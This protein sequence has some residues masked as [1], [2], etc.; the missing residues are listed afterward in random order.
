MIDRTAAIGPV[1][2]IRPSTTAASWRCAGRLFYAAADSEPR[3]AQRRRSSGTHDPQLVPHLSERCSADR[4]APRATSARMSVSET[5]K[6][7]HTILPRGALATGRGARASA[8]G[9]W[10]PFC[11]ASFSQTAAAVSPTSLRAG[12]QHALREIDV[13]VAGRR[14]VRAG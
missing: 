12:D 6:Q 13:L 8:G 14:G 11:M 5:S 9:M 4:S 7:L 2:V 10:T 3:P 1:A